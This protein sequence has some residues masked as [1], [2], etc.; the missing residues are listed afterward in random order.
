[1][2]ICKICNTLTDPDLR[3]MTSRCPQCGLVSST[4]LEL[5]DAID[6]LCVA[7]NIETPCVIPAVPRA[8]QLE[9]EQMNE[10]ARMSDYPAK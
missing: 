6:R 4:L 5:A 8:V 1:M 10:M 2:I 9:I 7:K 3:T